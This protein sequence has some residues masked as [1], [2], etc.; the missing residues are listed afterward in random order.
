MPATSA[1]PIRG[2][3]QIKQGYHRWCEL[4]AAG[5]AYRLILIVREQTQ[6]VA[7]FMRL[8][9][10]GTGAFFLR[11]EQSNRESFHT[12]VPVV[13]TGIAS[14]P[15]GRLSDHHCPRIGIRPGNPRLARWKT[16]R[17]ARR[18]NRPALFGGRFLRHEL[19]NCRRPMEAGGTLPIKRNGT[20]EK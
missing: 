6:A 13:R 17:T 20:L 4:L 14:M 18:T 2:L 8:P 7:P 10:H 12:T 16:E 15:I 11:F 5:S 3:G 19:G 9:A 1:D